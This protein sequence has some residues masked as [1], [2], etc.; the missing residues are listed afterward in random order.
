MEVICINDIF[1][2]E[3][4][5]FFKTHGVITPI[6]DTVYSIREIVTHSKGK[7]GIRLNEIVNHPVPQVHPILGS[8]KMEPSF[9]YTRFSLL[10]G[11]QLTEK[12]LTEF[13]KTLVNV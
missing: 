10:N 11:D 1:E 9:D 8:I 2:G 7:T 12:T 13:K 3:A 5:V 6:K 4:G